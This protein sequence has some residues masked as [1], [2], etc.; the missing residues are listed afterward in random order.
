MQKLVT[1]VQNTVE[2]Y[3]ELHALDRLEHDYRLKQ[4]EQ[5]GLSLRGDSLDILKQAVKVQSKHVKSMKKKSLWS[6][7]L[8]EVVVK[9][10]D[11]VHFL[12]LEIYNAFGHPDKEEPQER[13]KHHNRLGPAGLALH[14]ASIINQIDNLVSQ[15]CAMPPNARDALYHSLPP[16]IKSAL[17]YKL[18]S[19]EVKEELTASQV[20]AEMEKTLWWLVPLASNTNKAYHGF[21]WVGELANTG[22]EMNCK[23]SGQKDMSRIETL[24]HA[25]KEK[26]EALI[27]ELVVWLHHLISKSRHA[28]GGVRSP[29]KSPVSSPTQNG[30]AITLLPGKT[31]ISSP[32][33]T[34]EDQDML[35]DVKYRKFVPGI[36]KSQEF[37]TKSSHSKRSR[38]S[39]SNS[40]SPASGNR[41]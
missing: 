25:D 19:F 3:H 9:L 10:V 20:K 37:D 36:S 41:K 13:G 40:Q 26:T 33:L 23:L 11:I 35:R 8:E 29:I 12:H 16:I 28:S 7:N 22:S 27:L 6:K 1:C 15:S 18:Q 4:K 2:L 39:K 38:L 31:K 21:G 5:D 24:Y 34:Q 14:Y 30:A 17:R 32:I